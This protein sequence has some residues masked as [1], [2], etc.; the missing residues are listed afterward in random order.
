MF[1]K[2]KDKL[3]HDGRNLIEFNKQNT[4]L[5]SNK[6]CRLKDNLFWIPYI[7]IKN[8]F[9]WNYENLYFLALGIFQLMTISILPKEWSP[10]GPYSTAVPLALCILLEII[11]DIYRWLRNYR[12]DSKDNFRMVECYPNKIK[13]NELLTP[14]DVIKL[15]KEEI[16]PADGILIDCGDEKYGKLSLAPLNG[17]SQ[18][19]IVEKPSRTLKMQDYEGAQLTITNYHQNSYS[20]L[21]AILKIGDREHKLNG[22]SFVVSNSIVKSPEISIW[23]TRCGEEKKSWIKSKSAVIR[24]SRLDRHVASYMMNIN[25]Y[26]LISMIMII[27]V[28]KLLYLDQTSLLYGSIFLIVQNWILF[29]GVI[30]FSVKIFLI[31]V[32]NFQASRL[33]KTGRITVNSSILIDDINKADIIV[34]DKTGTLTKN[35]LE[36]TKL[37]QKGDNTLIDIDETSTKQINL[38]FLTCLGLCIHQTEDDYSTVE[39][40]TIRYRY[41]YLDSQVLQI[42]DQV[43]LILGNQEHQYRYVEI[44]GLDFSYARRM[45]SK[46]VRNEK[47]RHFI[48]SKGSVDVIRDKLI[49]EDRVELDRLDQLISDENPELRLLACAYRECNADELISGVSDSRHRDMCIQKLENDM[50]L[51]GIIGIRDNLQ[52][53]V[54]GTINSFKEL[55]LECA[56]CTG[57]RKITALAIAKDA[58]IVVDEEEVVDYDLDLVDQPDGRGKILLF[59]G[60]TIH[61]M[62]DNNQFAKNFQIDLSGC[63]SFIG[64]N[65]RPDDKKYL[66][67]LLEKTG[68]RVLNVGDGFN[69]ISM[70]EAGSISVAIKGNSFVED[71]ADFVIQNFGDLNKLVAEIGPDYYYRNSLLANFTFYRSIIVVICLATWCLLQYDRLTTAIFNGFVMQA[72]HI[73]WTSTPIIYFCLTSENMKKSYDKSKNQKLNSIWRTSLWNIAG[74]LTGLWFT[75]F[76]YTYYGNSDKFGDI[77]AFLVICAINIRLIPYG[78]WRFDRLITLAVGPTL[79]SLYSFYSGSWFSIISM[80]IMPSGIGFLIKLVIGLVLINLFTL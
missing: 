59:S 16:V 18:I 33:T 61:Q 80:F 44:S 48:Y 27:S 2:E 51:L 63:K 69:D 78:C 60:L 3:N 22:S 79:F 34:S 55:G 8:Y 67:K 57:D 49:L 9:F 14:G 4:I 32:R 28:I 1:K 37:I 38:D 19:H 40:K 47:M 77:L 5:A 65:L 12:L 11:T 20:N 21:D 7:T 15:V 73:F 62:K 17:E 75:M 70:F 42:G 50:H 10:T 29:N 52:E 25:S 58:G 30:P 53:G 26:L 72:F 39:D 23:V 6:S 64:Y 71:N 46:V 68:R 43:T 41:H 66:T 45:S 35:E 36:F 74:L 76:T 31:L 56:I 13:K 24:H 54:R